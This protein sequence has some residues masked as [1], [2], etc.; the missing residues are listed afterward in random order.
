MNRKELELKRRENLR[1]LDTGYRPKINAVELNINNSIKHE[2]AKFY[3]SWMIRKG[4]PIDSML[5]TIYKGVA[6]HKLKRPRDIDLAEYITDNF[7]Q[8][9]SRKWQRPQIVTEARFSKRLRADIF[10]LDTGEVIE[11][12]QT[13]SERSLNRKRKIYEN[14]GLKFYVVR[15]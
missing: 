7:G 15:V 5:V 9:F 2:A 12:A 14:M 8:K 13:E 11:I 4:V 10:V 6:T 1:L 3:I